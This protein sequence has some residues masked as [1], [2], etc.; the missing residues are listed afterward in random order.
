MVALVAVVP[1]IVAVS[2]WRGRPGVLS[3]QPF[4][5]GAALGAAAGLVHYLGTIYWTG[6]VVE[7]FGGLPGI[8]AWLCALA[9]ALYMSAYTALAC[10][11][12]GA[13]IQRAGAAGLVV[14]PVAWVAAEFAR[15]HV[16]GG[17]PWIPLGSAVVTLVPV[18]QLAS[19]VGVYGV[20][21]FLVTLGTLV[22]LAMMSARPTRT[23]AAISAV[24]LLLA[25]SAWGSAR[26]TDA[27]LTREGTPLTVGLIQPNVSQE[28]K[29]N[30]ARVGEIGRRYAALTRRAVADGAQA[31][32]WPE[33]STPYLF[34]EDPVQ[35][36]AVRAL[37]RESGVPLLFGTDEVERGEPDKYFNSAFVLDPSGAVAAVYRKMQLVP[38]GEYVPLKHLLFFVAPLVD[39]VAEFAPGQQVTM[40]PIAGHMA[41][42]AICYE[43]VYPHLIRRGVLAGAELLTTITNDAWYGDSSAPYQHFELAS[44]R[45]IEQGR[46]LA[47]AANTGISGVIDPYGRPVVATRVFEEA[48]VT[49]EVRFLQSRTL[50]ATIGDAVAI[51]SLAATL[52]VA[53]WL[54]ATRH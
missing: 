2:G 28:D 16:L 11:L 7:T 14:A 21:F 1:L 20:S 13:V 29:W 4:R 24:V 41:S 40:L 46:Y 35:A 51:A 33:S 27:R 53:A 54:A 47:R 23:A 32:L 5:R 3:G 19:L 48:V 8:V 34:N 18:A 38:F 9:L 39:A 44:M 31:I 25:A 26:V 43:V 50:Y 15:G 10:G 52:A 17:F 37:V 22:A 36:E 12:T 6:A 30:R 45:A 49:A 42:T